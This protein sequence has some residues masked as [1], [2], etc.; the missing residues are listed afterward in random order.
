VLEGA[1][2]SVI[3][4]VVQFLVIGAIGVWSWLVQRNDNTAAKVAEHAEK[5]SALE[6]RLGEVP[7]HDD[8]QTLRH[9]ISETRTGV[10][11][12]VGELKQIS[13]QLRLVNEH[14]LK[15]ARER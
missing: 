13:S 6:A 5:I 11:R 15:E 8:L 1:N 10:D 14:L 3:V 12:V 4:D 2:V 9:E 7:G